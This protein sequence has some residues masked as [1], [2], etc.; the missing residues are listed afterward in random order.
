MSSIGVLVTKE[1]YPRRSSL[2]M[3]ELTFTEIFILLFVCLVVACSSRNQR[4]QIKLSYKAMQ[5]RGIEALPQ[6]INEIACPRIPNTHPRRR[7]T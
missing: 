3:L 7:N 2:G 6:Y 5:R 4:K 1:W